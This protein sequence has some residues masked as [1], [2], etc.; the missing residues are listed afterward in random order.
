M[1]CTNEQPA[2]PTQHWFQATQVRVQPWRG[3]HHVYA[4]FIVPKQY[5]FDHLYTAKLRIHGVAMELSAGSPE[6]GDIIV[7]SPEPGFYSKSVELTTRSALW[8]LLKGR[9][10]DLSRSC[11][12]WLLIEDKIGD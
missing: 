11:H 5:K 6:D 8:L 12:W 7:D 9:Y 1:S 2:S 3:P 10:D 4:V